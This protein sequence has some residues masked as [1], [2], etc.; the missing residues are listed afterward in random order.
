MTAVD[1]SPPVTIRG[2]A[3]RY[4]NTTVL[5]GF[6]LDV[7]SGEFVTLLGPS[8][9]GKTTILMILAGFVR[10]NAGSIKV[11]EEEIVAMP[12]H[13]RNVG[14]VFQNYALFPHMDVFQ[15][16][17]FPLRQRAVGAAEIASRV[18]EALGLVQLGEYA[19]RRVDQLSGGQRQR[20]ALARAIVFEPRIL[21][22]D[23]PLSALDKKLRERMQI[24]IRHLHERLGMTTIYVTHDQR[25]A[26]TMSDRVAV[27]NAGKIAQ[28][29][30]PKGLYAR[31]RTRF[32]AEFI[33]ESNFLPVEVDGAAVKF[34]GQPLRIAE[35]I[36]ASATKQWLVIRPEKLSVLNGQVDP[37]LNQFQ[38]H[39]KE[40]V[41]Q[42]E[43]FIC[44]VTLT[45]GSEIS[46][47]NYSRGDALARLPQAG[48][49]IRLGLSPEDVVLVPEDSAA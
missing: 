25:E 40:V 21:L 49:P 42:G 22:M 31:P 3:K 37:A 41:Y 30:T 4:G 5:H 13:K 11:G 1:R 20:V 24:E 46:L 44:Y 38:G 16:V 47:R 45:D 29:D 28:L 35:T 33:G 12:P 2:I 32:V 43:S 26:I 27:M 18:R 17:A 10:P 36:G 14:M 48:Q 9:S 19:E 8:G 7:K 15:N 23:E 39:V 34:G 6:D